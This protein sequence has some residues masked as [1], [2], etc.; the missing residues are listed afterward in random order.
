MQKNGIT[1]LNQ[2]IL[3]VLLFAVWIVLSGFIKPLFI[4]FGLFSCFLTVYVA[5]LLSSGEEAIGNLLMR[6]VRLPLYSVWLFKEIMVSTL[7]VTR[8]VWHPKL[9]ISPV[10]AWV[11]TQQKDDVAVTCFA[12]SITLTPGTVSVVLEDGRICVH[13]LQRESVQSLAEGEMDRR[14]SVW[15]GE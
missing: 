7:Q 15:A 13:G 14:V 12:N 5:R 3:F 8:L 2:C 11:P 4:G 1:I 6:L 10:I 9:P